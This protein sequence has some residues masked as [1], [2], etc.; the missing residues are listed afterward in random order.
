MLPKYIFPKVVGEKNNNNFRGLS[1]GQTVCRSV[2]S[3]TSNWPSAML[4]KSLMMS[5]SKLKKWPLKTN[6]TR[7]Y[8]KQHLKTQHGADRNKMKPESQSRTTKT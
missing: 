8:G 7:S 4:P 6:Q 2:R 1:I 5:P 3:E